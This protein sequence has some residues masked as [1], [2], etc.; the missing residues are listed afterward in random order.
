MTVMFACDVI[1][2]EASR[3]TRVVQFAST[4]TA[5][6]L[7]P[8]PVKTPSANG[9]YSTAMRKLLGSAV[10]GVPFTVPVPSSVK[11]SSAPLWITNERVVSTRV[12]S[13][14]AF[15]DA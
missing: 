7:K 14:L 4:E 8:D 12:L 10:H 6:S 9:A 2:V 3:R 13:A 1:D 11:R 5:A 15:V